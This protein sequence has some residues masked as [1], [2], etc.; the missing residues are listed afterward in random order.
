MSEEAGKGFARKV[1]DSNLAKLAP[2]LRD[3]TKDP[4]QPLSEENAPSKPMPGSGSDELAAAQ[5]LFAGSRV[6]VQL[7]FTFPRGTPGSATETGTPMVEPGSNEGETDDDSGVGYSVLVAEIPGAG[8]WSQANFSRKVFSEFFGAGTIDLT[9]IDTQG[10][11]IHQTAAPIVKGSINFCYELRAAK[12]L[13]YPNKDDGRPIGVFLRL[14]TQEFQY[15]LV[16]PNDPA[17]TILVAFLANN[18]KGPARYMRR[19]ITDLPKLLS[20]WPAASL[21]LQ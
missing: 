21:P 10:T 4:T 12:K 1:T 13:A 5:S 18:W 11:Q 7:P 6:H 16:M 9:Y 20:A 15:R 19:V 8:R 3:R 17:H 2:L 14:G